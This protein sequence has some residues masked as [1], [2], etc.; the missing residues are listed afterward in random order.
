MTMNS[1]QERPCQIAINSSSYPN[2][3]LQWL[4]DMLNS[5]FSKHG[6]ETKYVPL[7]KHQKKDLEKCS[8]GILY[9][10]FGYKQINASKVSRLLPKEEFNYMSSCLGKQNVMV[11]LDDMD[12]N[13]MKETVRILSE[14]P[15]ISDCSSCLLLIPKDNKIEAFLDQMNSISR[16]L[17]KGLPETNQTLRTPASSPGDSD[18]QNKQTNPFDWTTAE[19]LKRKDS[20]MDFP[21]GQSHSVSVFSRC[22]KND[23]KWLV[24]QLR[25]EDFGSLVKEVHAVEISNDFS[26]FVSALNNCTFAI[27]Y[28]SLNHGC[29]NITTDTDSLYDKHLEVLSQR[30]GKEKVIVILDDLKDSSSQEKKSILHEQPNTERYSE[31]LLLFSETEKNE[32]INKSHTMQEKQGILKKALETSCGSNFMEASVFP[33]AVSRAKFFG[34]ASQNMN[35]VGGPINTVLGQKLDQ[36]L[37]QL[38]TEITTLKEQFDEVKKEH[39]MEISTLSQKHQSEIATLRQQLDEFKKGY[40]AEIST[41]SQKHQ[42]DMVNLKQQM[43]E[44]KNKDHRF[45]K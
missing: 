12:Q 21:S 34:P 44:F 32:G 41:L 20:K 38:L 1:T 2:N 28:H 5:Y 42:S 19:L 10:S 25:S 13:N 14:D 17:M 4:V 8:F 3:K 35:S 15:T 40:H 30:L 23:Y 27:L 16:F 31:A 18:A 36:T 37:K 43:D 22:A 45:P 33:S 26:H 29:L 24:A 39:H 9:Y 11:V 7:T 6:T